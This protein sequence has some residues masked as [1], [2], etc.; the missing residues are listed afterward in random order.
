M[1]KT[2]LSL[3]AILVLAA[4]SGPAAA[5]DEPGGV[6]LA[7]AAE[8]DIT[9]GVAEYEDRNGNGRFDYGDPSL[10]YGYG[11]RVTRFTDGEI[12][13]GNGNGTAL[14][15]YDPIYARALV[16]EDP[17]TGTR[18]ALVS[19]N[20]YLLTMAD[21]AAIRA[22]VDPTL[23]IDAIIIAA[24]HTHMGP[25]TLG[26]GAL[27]DAGLGDLAKIILWRG[28][29]P[30]GINGPW[31]EGMMRTVAGLIE[32]AAGNLRQARITLAS[33]PFSFGAHDLRE[34]HIFDNEMVVMGVDDLKG[35]PIATLVQWSCHPE[36][37]LYYGAAQGRDLGELDDDTIA[38]FGR[39][40]SAGFVGSCCREIKARRGGVPLYFNGALGGMITNLDAVL[41]DPEAH[42][43][44]PVDTDPERVP[45]SIRIP[46]DYRFAPIQGRELAKAALAALDRDGETARS[47]SIEYKS[48]EV[49]VPF[50]NKTLRLVSSLGIL[51]HNQGSL[52]GRSGNVDN[53][54]APWIGG[55]FLPAVR[56]GKGKNLRTEVAVATIGP[57][58]IA[59]VPAELLGELSAGLPEDFDSNTAR[60]F[61]ENA[62][63]HP[64]GPDYVLAHPPLKS[65]MTGKYKFIF[66]LAGDELGYVIPKCDFRPPHD[67]KIPPFLW[68]WICNDPSTDPHYEESM[69][70]GSLI[71]P[72]LMGA[73][74]ELLA[75]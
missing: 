14:Y 12:Y 21:T 11:D 7:G 37:V 10:A 66:C 22:M 34:P 52:Y 23:G 26:L 5:A 24:D 8:A 47:T 16:L 17:E 64:T 43:E 15:I 75:E 60:Y 1:K 25:D 28:K 59:C 4:L 44:Y 69:T 3:S 51:G 62:D 73:L 9:P 36:S 29:A 6:F 41:W 58:Q 30:S 65:S 48:R 68:W 71:E 35:S 67:L 42:P 63:A 57:A 72:R 53:R 74:N 31:F 70:V 2:V 40:L 33:Q 46:N 45:E 18:L 39:T 19:L 13:V 38:G 27:S 61:P 49:L 50:E 55:L 20:L 56:V 32:E 54:R